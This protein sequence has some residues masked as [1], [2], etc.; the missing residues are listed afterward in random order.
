MGYSISPLQPFKVRRQAQLSYLQIQSLTQL[1]QPIMGIQALSLYLTLMSMPMADHLWS[2]QFLHSQLLETVNDGIRHIQ[3]ALEK[4]EGI[5][6]LRTYRQRTSHSQAQFQSMIYDLQLPF[7]AYEFFN[8]PQLSTTLYRAIGDQEFSNRLKQWQVEILDVDEY[9]ELTADFQTIYNHLTLD[10]TNDISWQQEDAFLKHQQ[11][12]NNFE[13]KADDFDYA[14]FM[15]YILNE[16][17]NHKEITQA[18]KAYVLTCHQLYDLNEQEMSEVFKLCLHPIRGNIQL[19]RF[20][21]V[22][23]RMSQQKRQYAQDKQNNQSREISD[24]PGTNPNKVE[25]DLKTNYPELSSNEINLVKLSE[26]LDNQQFIQS[27]KKQLGGFATD[28]EQYYLSQL[29]EKS[30]LS[31]GVINIL[32]YYLLIILKRENVFKS[33]LEKH[34]NIWQQKGFKNSAEALIFTRN[35]QKVKMVEEKKPN[36]SRSSYYQSNKKTEM[37]PDWM[38]G[39]DKD[40]SEAKTSN[41]TKDATIDESSVRQQLKELFGKEE[42]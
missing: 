24:E 2:Q 22:S 10:Q 17:F 40:S 9:D 13:L 16:N 38:K 33:E 7:D 31:T 41:Q 4:L 28:S 39:T 30:T 8:H 15:S 36:P 18:L 21:E 27:L 14:K 11:A 23:E 20:N 6:L 1:Y 37:V 35:E 42:D 5:G 25:S 26:Q 19:E 3:S 32:I 34:A 12:A 29:K